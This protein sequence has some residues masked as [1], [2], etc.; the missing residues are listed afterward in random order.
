MTGR[1]PLVERRGG[2]RFRI[3]VRVAAQPDRVV[4][5]EV[6]R[7]LGAGDRYGHGST[8]RWERLWTEVGPPPGEEGER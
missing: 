3:T 1:R 4:T 2:D 8:A 6:L 7:V 5:R